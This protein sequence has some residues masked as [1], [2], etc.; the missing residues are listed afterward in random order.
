MKSIKIIFISVIVFLFTY[1]CQKKE[2]DYSDPLTAVVLADSTSSPMIATTANW[3]EKLLKDQNLCLTRSGAYKIIRHELIPDLGGTSKYAINVVEKNDRV[4]FIPDNDH[5]FYQNPGNPER[6]LTFEQGV[7]TMLSAEK[8]NNSVI[9][10]SLLD[11]LIDSLSFSQTKYNYR[12]TP[13]NIPDVQ[14]YLQIKEDDIQWNAVFT[15]ILD[16]N[17]MIRYYLYFNTILAIKIIPSKEHLSI[18][19]HLLYPDKFAY[20]TW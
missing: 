5:L 13:E 17:K 6:P 12:I 2:T 1:A 16:E 14:R 8:I 11:C 10:Y 15:D 7:N 3:K 19:T 4:F 20:A 18:K 9:I